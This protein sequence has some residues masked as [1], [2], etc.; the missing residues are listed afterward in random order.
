MYRT[1]RVVGSVQNN[2]SNI[3]LMMIFIIWQLINP[4]Y[5]NAEP[6]CVD[7]SMSSYFLQKTWLDYPT[8][9]VGALRF[10]M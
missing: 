4:L 7:V 9:V 10:N 8:S 1:V 2:T 3:K 5:G 6:N